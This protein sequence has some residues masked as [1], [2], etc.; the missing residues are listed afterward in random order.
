MKRLDKALT[1]ACTLDDS[2]ARLNVASQ[3][4]SFTIATPVA[5]NHKASAS[6]SQDPWQRADPWNEGTPTPSSPVRQAPPQAATAAASFGPN[7]ADQA[8]MNA[9]SQDQSSIPPTWGGNGAF[10][11][12]TQPRQ[13][14]PMPQPNM[15][16]QTIFNTPAAVSH[17]SN[18]VQ[19][20]GDQDAM[21]RK[22]ESVRR[23]SGQ[24]VDFVNWSKRMVNHMAKVHPYLRHILEWLAVTKQE[25]S[26]SRLTKETLGP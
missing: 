19:Y 2:R 22:S 24:S 20:M 10:S 16:G 13:P 12:S 25:M 6:A 21:A 14:E 3:A 15:M 8:R 26:L 1:A 23:F 7:S 18:K 17:G 11:Q 9:N 4:Q 5:D